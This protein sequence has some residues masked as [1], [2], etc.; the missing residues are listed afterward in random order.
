VKV[1]WGKCECDTV[2][3]HYFAFSDDPEEECWGDSPAHAYVLLEKDL[4]RKHGITKLPAP[5][6]WTQGVGLESYR[7]FMKNAR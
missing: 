5:V 3:P 1:Y 6:E 7:A 4:K 2:L